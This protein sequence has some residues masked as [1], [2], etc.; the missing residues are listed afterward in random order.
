ME[1]N[2]S[3]SLQDL[4]DI[5]NSAIS[6]L[7]KNFNYTNV[8]RDA[9]IHI[10]FSTNPETFLNYV[11]SCST[12]SLPMEYDT[13]ENAIYSITDIAK[14]MVERFRWTEIQKITVEPGNIIEIIP[15]PTG[16]EFIVSIT[17]LNENF[18]DVDSFFPVAL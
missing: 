13:K 14:Q 16:N 10:P 15:A 8:V 9:N 12:H 2:P 4:E 3:Y 18:A 5:K 7:K 17:G 1:T 11:W 6:E